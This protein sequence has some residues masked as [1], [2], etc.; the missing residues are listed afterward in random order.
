MGTFPAE[1]ISVMKPLKD[2]CAIDGESVEFVCELSKPDYKVTWM[3]ADFEIP[4]DSDTYK[5][6]T[7]GTLYKLIIPKATVDMTSQFTIKAGDVT[8]CANL[9]VSGE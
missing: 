7:D 9:T 1:P 3:Q 6:E 2:V 5:Q 8:S 4:L